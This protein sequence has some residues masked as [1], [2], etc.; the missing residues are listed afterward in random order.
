MTAAKRVASVSLL[1]RSWFLPFTSLLLVLFEMT[2][3]TTSLFPCHG[4]V[5][6]PVCDGGSATEDNPL[7][8]SQ[9]INGAIFPQWWDG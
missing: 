1:S 7:P 8:E 5:L 2:K 3:L 9:M 6:C 4:A